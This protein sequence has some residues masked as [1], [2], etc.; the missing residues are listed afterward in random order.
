M[1]NLPRTQSLVLLVPDG[2]GGTDVL[3]VDACLTE[4]HQLQ[5]TVTD[6][7]V[8]RGVRITD[9]VRPEPRRLTLECVVTN[10]PV[11]GNTPGLD[12]AGGFWKRLVDL[13]ESP[14]IIEVQTLRDYYPSMVVEA[15]TAP[16]DAKTAQALVFTVQLKQV[17]VV[18]NKLTRVV[19]AKDTRAHRTRKA[20]GATTSA[21]S[22]ADRRNVSAIIELAGTAVR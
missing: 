14:R 21:V 18:E 20:G 7:P 5:E 22:D 17:R 11:R 16:V 12:Y 13:Y 4:N 1:A 2:S 19:M 10:T 3:T 6:H 15:V 8:E 9:H